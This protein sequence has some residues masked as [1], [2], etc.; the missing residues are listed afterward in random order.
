MRPWTAS[1][2]SLCSSNRQNRHRGR[3][4]GPFYVAVI[5]WALS[6]SMMEDSN[7][8]ANNHYHGHYYHYHTPIDRSMHFYCDAAGATQ[9]AYLDRACSLPFSSTTD[10]QRLADMITS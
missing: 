3:F 9:V 10:Y 4:K 5:P 8:T 1:N 7:G 2:P 6:T